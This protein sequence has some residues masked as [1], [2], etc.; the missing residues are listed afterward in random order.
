MKNV[1]AMMMRR[2]GIEP[3][4]RRTMYR[5]M[6]AAKSP[7]ARRWTCRSRLRMPVCADP[8]AQLVASNFM[9][10]SSKSM[11]CFRQQLPSE[12]RTNP[13][14][15]SGAA[16]GTCRFDEVTAPKRPNS[17]SAD[18]ALRGL[19][20]LAKFHWRMRKPGNARRAR[21]REDHRHVGCH[22]RPDGDADSCRSRR[23]GYQDR[24]SRP[25]RHGALSRP[26]IRRH[27]AMFAAVNRNKRSML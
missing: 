9:R 11:C 20:A 12:R 22:C 4:S 16:R 1:I 27:G 15:R 6:L 2:V 23:R 10:L 3:N 13:H 5:N 8:L 17:P 7:E 25:R 24:K 14:G 21:R 19:L 26:S 18:S